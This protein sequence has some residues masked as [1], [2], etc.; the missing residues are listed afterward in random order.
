[1]LRAYARVIESLGGR[2]ITSVDVGST[3]DDLDEMRRETRHVVGV[4]QAYGGSGDPAPITAV[5][6]AS[7]IRSSVYQVFR[8]TSLL[9]RRVVIQGA[10]KVG[11]HLAGLLKH[12][13]ADVVVAD[14]NLDS[15]ARAITDFGVDATSA[16]GA[17]EMECDVLAP[18]AL[19][20][21][22]NQET[23]PRLKC[24]IVCGSANNQL[25]TI[26]DGDALARAEILYAPDFIV[27]AGGLISVADEMV[28]WNHDRV[29][30][31][32]EKI[33][34]TLLDVFH[35]AQVENVSTAEAA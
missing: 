2:Y 3:V 24:R 5:G 20:G 13:G 27:N 7:A 31:R 29:M 14:P 33:G 22:I 6:V 9:G 16:D 32:V 11:Y 17:L 23:I 18:C 19:G 28:G 26:E 35:I 8:D 21:V 10:G 4:S 15:V 30:A 25:A 12:E 34:R 1:L